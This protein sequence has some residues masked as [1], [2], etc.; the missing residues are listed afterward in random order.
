MTSVPIA[1]E[2]VEILGSDQLLYGTCG[3]D[4]L[5]ARINANRRVVPGDV[6]TLGLDDGV[7]HLFDTQTEQA[8]L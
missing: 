2:I 1:V 6:V 8:L 4:R 7:V 3:D 5:V